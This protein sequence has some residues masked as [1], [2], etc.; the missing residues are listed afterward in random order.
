MEDSSEWTVYIIQTKSGKLYTGITKDLD[1]R[2]AEHQNK[3]KGARFFNISSPEKIVYRESH[4]S[5]S[6]AAKREIKIKKM[7]RRQKLDLCI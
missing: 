5:R 1:R 6:E 4:I 2:F 7:T 3:S